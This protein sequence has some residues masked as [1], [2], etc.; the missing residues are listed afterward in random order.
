[1]S[2]Q[3]THTQLPEL[4]IFFTS[5]SMWKAEWLE[6]VNVYV[7]EAFRYRTMDTRQC[8]MMCEPTLSHWITDIKL[9]KSYLITRIGICC[10][11]IGLA[12]ENSKYL[13]H[14]PIQRYWSQIYISI[15][16]FHVVLGMSPKP[17]RALLW[18]LDSMGWCLDQHWVTGSLISNFPRCISSF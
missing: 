1:M 11:A 18:T 10:S 2:H 7:L 9:S 14:K 3:I 8:W 17:S 5:D 15:H 12:I 13:S 16:L 6:Y 4:T